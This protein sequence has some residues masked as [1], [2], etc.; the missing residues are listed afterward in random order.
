MVA[1]YLI[2]IQKDKKFI[3]L[4]FE[5]N[6]VVVEGELDLSEGAKLFFENLKQ[7]VDSYIKLRL[8]GEKK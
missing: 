3:G 4:K 8:K 7:C 1:D 5:K 2:M 6:K